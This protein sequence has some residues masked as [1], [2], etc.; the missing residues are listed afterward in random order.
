[1]L[2]L[3]LLAFT[4]LI[5]AVSESGVRRRDESLDR[6]G[7]GV[8]S[9]DVNEVDPNNDG[10]LVH[11]SGPL[12]TAVV[13]RDPVFG[14]EVTGSWLI[15]HSQQYSRFKDSEGDAYFDW[16]DEP[17]APESVASE[18]GQEGPAQQQRGRTKLDLSHS[19]PSKSWYVQRL[20]LGAFE[21]ENSVGDIIAAAKPIALDQQ[22]IPPEIR[23]Q[24]EIVN[25][26]TL[27]F[28]TD[29]MNPQWGDRRVRFLTRPSFELSLIG[30]QDGRTLQP[31]SLAGGPEFLK[32]YGIVSADDLIS[33]RKAQSYLSA[34]LTRG[35]I[36]CL[37][38]ACLFV[39]RKPAAN[40][41]RK[42]THV[43]SSLTRVPWLFPLIGTAVLAPLSIFLVSQFI[44]SPQQV[45]VW[46]AAA[47]L[48]GWAIAMIGRRKAV[49]STSIEP[50][51][52]ESN[53]IEQHLAEDAAEIMQAVERSNA[54]P[55]DHPF[56]RDDNE[57][58]IE[59]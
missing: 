6:V 3:F 59:R 5:L 48:G 12:T 40:R 10:R 27:F 4:F 41:I 20:S 23:Q 34:L 43:G 56:W 25:N 47:L 26:E 2:G 30:K 39:L 35:F 16:S 15:R 46:C 50:A 19:I 18:T 8:V 32:A 29:R 38:F 17:I 22:S 58:L 44:D 36:T 52:E 55:A 49:H 45:I 31:V 7:Q 54:P 33:Q 57:I 42:L 51:C 14:V 37:F 21:V 1:M 11:V 13:L 53:L 24:A 28:G 9:V